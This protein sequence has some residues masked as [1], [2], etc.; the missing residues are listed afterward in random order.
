MMRVIVE[1]HPHGSASDKRTIA[2]IDIANVSELAETSDYLVTATFDDGPPRRWRVCGHRRRDGW[3]PLV[4]G[5]LDR[6][7]SPWS[8]P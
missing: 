2:T 6:L 5:V 3:I 1:I 4:R 7:A 8:E